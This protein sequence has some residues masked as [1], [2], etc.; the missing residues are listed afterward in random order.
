MHGQGC[1]AKITN[2]R[3]LIPSLQ[4]KV[5]YWGSVGLTGAQVQWCKNRQAHRRQGA[6]KPQMCFD[7]E[8]SVIIYTS[9][10]G[11][12]LTRGVTI[13]YSLAR[14]LLLQFSV[15]LVTSG[16]TGSHLGPLETRVRQLDDELLSAIFCS[17]NRNPT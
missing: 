10:A 4:S 5:M 8:N 2:L 1:F 11:S 9:H 12:S 7:P 3:P 16:T 13:I 15:R 17:F 14:Q 6:I